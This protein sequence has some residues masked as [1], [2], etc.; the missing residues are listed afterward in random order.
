M[1]KVDRTFTLAAFRWKLMQMSIDILSHAVSTNNLVVSAKS[2]KSKH[3]S[4]EIRDSNA[5]RYLS[6][7]SR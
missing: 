5:S 2:A 6:N 4:I 1:K 3:F 7:S